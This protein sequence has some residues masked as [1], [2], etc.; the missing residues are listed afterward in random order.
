V[1]D[2]DA[3]RALVDRALADAGVGW[4]AWPEVAASELIDSRAR[5]SALLLLLSAPE[6]RVGCAHGYVVV[7]DQTDEV[8]DRL[9]RRRLPWDRATAWLAVKAVTE[10]GAFDDRRVAIALRGAETVSTAGEADA[11][12]VSSLEDCASWLDD[13]PP[14]VWG[15]AQMRLLAR[16]VVAAATPPDLLDLSLVR[17][18]DAWAEPARE[19]ARALAADEIAPLVRSLGELGPRKPS[20]SWLRGV[21]EALRPEAARGLLQAWLELAAD[22][23]VVPPDDTVAFS[24]GVLFSPGN[25]DLVRAAVLATRLLPSQTWIPGLLGVLARRGAA[26]SGEPGMTASLAL[27]VA[28]A[29]VDTLAARGTPADREVLEEML[30][31]LSRRD[32]VK[33]VGEALGRQAEATERIEALRR[34]KAAAVRR[35]ADPA[36][37]RAR[38]TADALLRQHLGPELRRHGFRAG[39][40]TWRRFHEDRVDVVAFGSSGHNVHLTYGTR[41]D[42]AHPDGELYPVDRA[43]VRDFHLDVR[44]LEDWSATGHDLDRC[45]RHLGATVIPFLDTLAR[46]ELARAYLEH[47]AGAPV[48][49]DSIEIPGSPAVSGVLG[50]LASAAGD[51]ATAVKHLAHR[52]AAAESWADWP[53]GRSGET[54]DA[55]VAFWRSQLDQARRR[56]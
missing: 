43:K 39:G 26:T 18:G 52:V 19:T 56:R 33:R 49:A 54:A 32:L 30:V 5:L 2:L 4:D 23:D 1:S 44:L 37:R 17:Q 50:L 8:L 38:A 31:D 47:G 11:T 6:H 28:S 29:A 27:K 15:V 21:E 42:A 36:P 7:H 10:R 22:T 13:L 46:Y 48:A 34:E 9:R 55:E 24:G 53:G 14:H 41:F 16:R 35:K 3:E 25:E 51:R 12:L 40:R 20:Q 45:A